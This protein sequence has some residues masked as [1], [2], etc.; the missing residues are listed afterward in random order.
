MTG[1]LL[2][3][4]T[5]DAAL[6]GAAELLEIAF[7]DDLGGAHISLA[8]GLTAPTRIVGCASRSEALACIAEA[9]A[10]CHQVW[11]SKTLQ[12]DPNKR[13]TEGVMHPMALTLDL[14]CGPGKDHATQSEA[15][16]ALARFTKTVGIKPSL[17]VNSGHG[18]HCWY[19]LDAPIEP[20]EWDGLA[21][22]LKHACDAFG[23]KVD[24][25]VT[26]NISGLMRVP[27]SMNRKGAA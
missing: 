5:Q 2:P 14:D 22:A 7:P 20:V 16:V 19:V 27:N 15:A 17:V 18:L 10:Q 23:L 21:K 8:T 1:I 24:P 6:S 9:I 3:D 13:N 25:A 26:T 11:I 4:P 12:R